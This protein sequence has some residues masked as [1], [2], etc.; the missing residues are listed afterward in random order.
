MKYVVFLGDGMADVSV[1]ELNGKT[2]LDAARHPAMDFLAQNGEFGM[3][4]TVP[5]GMKP[6]SDTANLAV[7]GYDPRVYYS[8]RS[9]LEAASIGIEL[10]P[11]DVTYRCNLVTLSEAA[12]ID[13]AAMLDY[14]AGEI[15]SAEAR[16]LV[17][18]INARFED[19]ALRLYP[20]VSYRQCFV[21]RGAA[22]GADL[23]PP[24]DISR[25]P[26][27][28]KLPKGQN[29]AL[30]REMMEY[31]Y[32]VLREH[33]VNRARVQAGKNPANAIWFWGE[34]RRPA[35]KPF[36]DMRGV[37]GG[38]ISA[39]DLIQGIGKCAGMRVIPV[40]GATGNYHTNFAGKGQAAIA[41]LQTDCDFVYI[42]VEAPDECGHQCQI[43]EKVYAIEQIDEKIIR[44]VLDYLEETGEDY[45][46]LLLP[47]HPTP[48]HLMTHTG[49]P[50][51]YVIYRHIGGH[52]EEAGSHPEIRY[53]ESAAAATGLFE[54]AG[55]RLLDRLMKK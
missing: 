43:P 24:H 50:V 48:V 3:V 21:M 41:A 42:H 14:S 25:Q 37:R 30:L 12:T 1:P 23:T 13:E 45:A 22:E 18:V 53:T 54:P 7:F 47:D 55:H 32:A 27:A 6:G 15:S 31:A 35:L 11:E 29:A 51:P 19:T 2:P 36:F 5:E 38:V 34:G 10:A 39:V 26:V 33:P 16:E 46:V 4:R 44:P 17:D 49:D 40:E 28:G 8:G 9:P 52:A 20:G